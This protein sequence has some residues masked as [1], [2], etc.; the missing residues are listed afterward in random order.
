MT[1][2]VASHFY[3]HTNVYVHRCLM[4]KSHELWEAHTWMLVLAAVAVAAAVVCYR[5]CC[6]CSSY[7]YPLL[8]LVRA[9]VLLLLLPCLQLRDLLC[10]QPRP[11]V[12]FTLAKNSTPTPTQSCRM[13]ESLE[14]TPWGNK[15]IGVPG[16][17][18]PGF[19]RETVLNISL[20]FC[21]L[22]FVVM[23]SKVDWVAS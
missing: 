19:G 22:S 2:F 18:G 12:L 11:L 23:V 4:S 21:F 3:I 15:H 9:P 14:C 6:K 10:L 13:C 16:L 20:C 17:G 1:K 5:C 7:C 8:L